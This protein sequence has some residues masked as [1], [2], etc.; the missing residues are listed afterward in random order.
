MKYNGYV[1]TNFTCAANEVHHINLAF[2]QSVDIALED[3]HFD[4]LGI[5]F[6][7]DMFYLKAWPYLGKPLKDAEKPFK[8]REIEIEPRTICSETD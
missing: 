7:E 5:P 6:I 3:P 1:L 2:T 8:I 4:K